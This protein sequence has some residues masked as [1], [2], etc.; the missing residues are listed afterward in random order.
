M[1]Q[2]EITVRV[3]EPLDKAIIKLEKFS[4]NPLQNLKKEAC[5]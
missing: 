5:V 2:I 3:K 4:E 1:R